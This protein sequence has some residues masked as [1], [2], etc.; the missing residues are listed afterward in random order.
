M[1]LSEREIEEKQFTYAQ[2]AD[3]STE[4]LSAVYSRRGSTL[5]SV[6]AED[7]IKR[8]KFMGAIIFIQ[9]ENKKRDELNAT[10]TETQTQA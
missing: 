8:S 6:L 5:L 4:E 2:L 9:E 7:E 3:L 1:P 10:G